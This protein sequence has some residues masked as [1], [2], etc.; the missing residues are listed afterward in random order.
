MRG[1]DDLEEFTVKLLSCYKS[2][3]QEIVYLILVNNIQNVEQG[4][5]ECHCILEPNA[6]NFYEQKKKVKE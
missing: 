5:V 2:R 6:Q 3:R 1:P 4:S